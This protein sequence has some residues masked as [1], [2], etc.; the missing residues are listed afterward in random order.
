ML[1]L[2][3]LYYLFN[4][5]ALLPTY[6]TKH[7]GSI[8]FLWFFWSS[9]KLKRAVQSPGPTQPILIFSVWKV[10][11]DVPALAIQYIYTIAPKKD[12]LTNGTALQFLL[13]LQGNIFSNFLPFIVLDSNFKVLQR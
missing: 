2:A 13:I 6:L 11:A 1:K 8:Y 4:D 5:F 7:G 9:T 3:E 10:F 12:G